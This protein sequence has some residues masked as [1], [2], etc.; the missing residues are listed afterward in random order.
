MSKPEYSDNN[1]P[2][3]DTIPEDF[4]LLK[5]SVSQP[6]VQAGD[7]LWSPETAKWEVAEVSELGTPIGAYKAVARH[8]D[9]S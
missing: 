3:L 8:E 7:L 1:K 6:W 5:L 4:L 9:R 2:N